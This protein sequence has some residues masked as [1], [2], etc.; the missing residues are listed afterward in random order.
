MLDNFPVYDTENVNYSATTILRVEFRIVV[1]RHEA[2]FG[3]DSFESCP[4]FRV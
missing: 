1:N 4:D 2:A 3:N